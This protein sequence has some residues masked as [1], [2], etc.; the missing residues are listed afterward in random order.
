MWPRL[1]HGVKLPFYALQSGSL[2]WGGGGKGREGGVLMQGTD[3]LGGR[4]RRNGRCYGI[5]LLESLEGERGEGG[6][7]RNDIK[8]GGEG[9]RLRA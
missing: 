6:T 8:E 1:W 4:G 5:G 7:E 9:G 2:D 3:T